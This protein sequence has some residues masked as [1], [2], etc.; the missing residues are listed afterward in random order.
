MTIEMDQKAKDDFLRSIDG[1]VESC[2]PKGKFILY[3][4]NHRFEFSE[5]ERQN[6]LAKITAANPASLY[7][8]SMDG[9]KPKLGRYKKPGIVLA[10]RGKAYGVA[11]RKKQ[12]LEL[13]E[14]AGSKEGEHVFHLG[15]QFAVSSI[16]T[17]TGREVNDE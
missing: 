13:L 17:T 12:L 16:W 11:N 10:Y 4:D 8:Y 7:V 3:L 14:Q 1:W 5:A 9:R 6:L 2:Q 15:I